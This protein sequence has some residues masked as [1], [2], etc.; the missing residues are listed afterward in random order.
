MLL[1]TPQLNDW[2]WIDAIQMGMPVFAKMGVLEKDNRYFEKMYE[3]Y[4]RLLKGILIKRKYQTVSPVKAEGQ[5]D[6]GAK[7]VDEKNPA[8]PA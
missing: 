8:S 1:N 5:K 4:I 7:A 2:Y 6:I 3:M